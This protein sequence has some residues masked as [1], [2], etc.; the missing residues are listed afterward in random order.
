MRKKSLRNRAL[1]KAKESPGT[2]LLQCVDCQSPEAQT[3]GQ[4]RG[5]ILPKMLP[6]VDA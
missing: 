3:P 4:I 1:G 2:K 6:V 5:I